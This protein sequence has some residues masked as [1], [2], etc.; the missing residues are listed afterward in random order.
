MEDIKKVYGEMKCPWDHTPQSTDV[1][2]L[3]R[4]APGLSRK[5]ERI[6]VSGE[7]KTIAI[8][9][10]A[11]HHQEDDKR[12]EFITFKLSGIPQKTLMA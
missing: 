6:T 9:A 12:R 11:N 7:N 2:E 1:E 5:E 3:M 4:R 8:V 10:A